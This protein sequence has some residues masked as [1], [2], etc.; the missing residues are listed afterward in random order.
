LK[1]LTTLDQLST[2]K[3]ST[4]TNPVSVLKHSYNLDR[5]SEIENKSILAGHLILQMKKDIALK[6]I[7]D[8]PIDGVFNDILEMIFKRYSVL[9]PIEIELALQMERYG[10]FET[11]TE[12]YQFYGT[13]YIAEVLRKYV[14]WKQQKAQELNL[15]R[16]PQQI[17]QQIDYE[18]IDREYLEVILS[19]LRAGK[20]LRHINAN[21]LYESIPN[22]EKL[23]ENQR[24]RLFK[25]EE[26]KLKAENELKKIKEVDQAKV[27]RL[28]ELI[29]MSFESNLETRCKNVATCIWLAK[30]HNIEIKP[31][32]F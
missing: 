27:K 28:G 22:E 10:E 21:K 26:K 17:E 20:I 7:K 9:T 31:N 6:G 18:K 1:N 13:E 15:S 30:K 12:H 11:K 4:T 3:N 29:E 5:I 23:T 2:S 14:N 25:H 8:M 16:K 19:D 32:Q 24:F